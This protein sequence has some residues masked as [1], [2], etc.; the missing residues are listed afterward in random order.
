MSKTWV[1][2]AIACCVMASTHSPA[3]AGVV[4]EEHAVIDFLQMMKVESRQVTSIEGD[5]ARL[6]EVVEL[7]TGPSD[8]PEGESMPR[9]EIH[10]F[11][12]GVVYRPIEGARQY[13]EIRFASVATPP[14]SS[15]QFAQVASGLGCRWA[16]VEVVSQDAAGHLQ[17]DAT[18]RCVAGKPSASSCTL[19]MSYDQWNARTD[20]LHAQLAR[21]HREYAAR[22]GNGSTDDLFGFFSQFGVPVDPALLDSIRTAAASRGLPLRT[23]AVLR[24]SPSCFGAGAAQPAGAEAVD[25][26]A[27][28]KFVGAMLLAAWVE[29]RKSAAAG[30]E[31]AEDLGTITTDITAIRAQKFPE[32]Q[33]EVPAGYT[34]VD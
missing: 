17:I 22:T 25:A 31:R 8:T 20:D 23:H 7:R 21:Y 16:K 27:M 2:A 10:R 32:S 3:R 34:K 14:D 26:S 29:E 33:F 5:K 6:E 24:A 28:P 1:T 30:A 19:G 11:D 18:H 15:R 13:R 4:A 9:T 12:R